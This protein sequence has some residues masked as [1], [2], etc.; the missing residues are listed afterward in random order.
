MLVIRKKLANTLNYKRIHRHRAT[1][2]GT[3]QL[4]VKSWS[5]PFMWLTLI[6]RPNLRM[7]YTW[8][9]SLLEVS[10]RTLASSRTLSYLFPIPDNR[11]VMGQSTWICKLW[12]LALLAAS[13]VM[14]NWLE[15]VA[16]HAQMS[17]SLTALVRRAKS[18]PCFSD[19]RPQTFSQKI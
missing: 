5:L 11:L 9:M 16:Q 15:K 10:P 1:A 19:L 4:A 12:L 3:L 2:F 6:N 14:E 18:V 17:I 13:S 7:R 8:K